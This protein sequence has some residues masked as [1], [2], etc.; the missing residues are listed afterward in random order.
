[1]NAVAIYIALCQ[2]ENI[3]HCLIEVFAFLRR[4]TA[5]AQDPAHAIGHQKRTFQTSSDRSMFQVT[6]TLVI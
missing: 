6:L 3:L 5:S 1:M 4:R 2:Y